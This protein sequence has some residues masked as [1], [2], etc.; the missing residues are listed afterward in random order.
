MP[1]DVKLEQFSGPLDLLLNLIH[2]KQ[3]N[4]SEISLSQVT[5]QFL[6]YVDSLEE[7]EAEELSDFLLV[8]SRLLLLKAR[9]LMP[10]FAISDDDD[11]PSL[12]DQLRLY[13]L[14]VQ[15]SKKLNGLWEQSSRSVFRFEPPRKAEGFVAPLNVSTQSVQGSMMGLLKRLKPPKPLPKTTIDKTISMKAKID[16]IRKILSSRKKAY[17][18]DVVQSSQNKTE[19][20]VSFLALLELVKQRSAFLHQEATFGDIAI[21]AGEVV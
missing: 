19:V 15:A 7:K 17:F 21:E 10:Q 6:Q 16:H 3:L 4:I 1:T 18:F 14:F 9:Y 12:E 2:E 11:G 13:K 8:A 20:I 5:E